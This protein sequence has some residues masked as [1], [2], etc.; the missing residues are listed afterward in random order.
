MKLSTFSEYLGDH[1]KVW[2]ANKEFSIKL[3]LLSLFTMTIFMYW[4]SLSKQP[5]MYFEAYQIAIKPTAHFFVIGHG[6][7]STEEECVF[8]FSKHKGKQT[9]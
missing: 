7:E 4:K 6:A 3:F 1:I 5:S 8:H 2:N 9:N